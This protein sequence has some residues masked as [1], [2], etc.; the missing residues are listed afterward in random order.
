MFRQGFTLLEL[1]IVLVIIGMVIGGVILGQDMIKSA[2]R[3]AIISEIQKYHS[4]ITSFSKKYGQLPGD[5]NN[6]VDYWG[7]AGGTGSDET[8]YMAQT[9]SNIATCNGD[10]DGKTLVGPVQYAERFLAW[11]HLAN[12]ELITGQY[13]GRT[14]DA[15]ATTPL[16]LVGSGG[17]CPATVKSGNSGFDQNTSL[18]D[19][20]YINYNPLLHFVE[21][22]TNKASLSVA[23][24]FYGAELSMIDSKIDDGSPVYGLIFTNKLTAV[25][26]GGCVTSDISTATYN[27][28][29]T[30]AT[31]PLHY[32]ISL[33]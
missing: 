6:A 19:H 11:K 4:A 9:A 21:S 14:G 29:Y 33:D 20:T 1:S 16:F 25:T 5:M 30:T 28:T 12:A 26:G 10:G 17:N 15:V 23:A 18:Y 24:T 7:S 8:C 2:E 22:K 32:I 31:C 27:Q 3:T 13:T